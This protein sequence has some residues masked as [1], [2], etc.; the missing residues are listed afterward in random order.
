MTSAGVARRPLEDVALIGGCL[1]LLAGSVHAGLAPAHFA[2]A[3]WLGVAFVLAAAGQTLWA[4]LALSG[5]QRWQ[6]AFGLVVN[7]GCVVCWAVSRTVGLPGEGLEPV[8]AVDLVTAA[9][10]LSLCAMLL[11]VPRAQTAGLISAAMLGCVLAGGLAAH[12]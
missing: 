10:E 6:V 9:A 8:G 3:T 4:M 5:V 7:L 2:E 1:S 12:H 11:R